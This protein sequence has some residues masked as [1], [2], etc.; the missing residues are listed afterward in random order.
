MAYKYIKP[1]ISGFCALVAIL[2]AIAH[3]KDCVDGIKV[4][5]KKETDAN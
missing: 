4:L 5:S 1:A 3:G 2:T